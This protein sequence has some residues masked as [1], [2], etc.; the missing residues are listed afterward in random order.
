MRAE[1][2]SVARRE[3]RPSAHLGNGF[4]VLAS[5]NSNQVSM[6]ANRGV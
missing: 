6:C 2:E 1:A 5:K 4:D 3:V